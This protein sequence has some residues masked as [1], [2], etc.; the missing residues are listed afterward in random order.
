MRILQNNHN[1]IINWSIPLIQGL[2]DSLS[3]HKSIPVLCN[4]P[5]ALNFTS[6]ILLCNLLLLIGSVIMYDNGLFPSLQ[7][8]KRLVYNNMSSEN[9]VD[10]SFVLDAA[11]SFYRSFWILPVYF[12]CYICN[13]IW[14]QDLANCLCKYFKDDQKKIASKK[15]RDL[16]SESVFKAIIWII[17][18]SKVQIILQI[19]PHF[20]N[21]LAT[22]L[23]DKFSLFGFGMSIFCRLF[24]GLC[25]LI[26]LVLMSVVYAWYSFDATWDVMGTSL[27]QRFAAMD[28]NWLYFVGFGLHA[29]II[30]KSSS[31]FVGYGLFMLC[32]PF[33][34]IL[35]KVSSNIPKD[36]D[37]NKNKNSGRDVHIP[38]FKTSQ[39]IAIYILKHFKFGAIST[40][41]R[42]LTKD[43]KIS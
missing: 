26:G 41:K 32:F 34:I 6:K 38:F 7:Y 2:T 15:S 35:A 22:I 29:T 20:G 39:S 11:F 12:L 18:F 5:E 16:I 13:T 33:S 17:V 40:K 37:S 19:F 23:F 14:C 43:K 1:V 10:Q 21:S 24:A 8:L 36:I 3:L 27:N 30:I 9:V 42:E 28:S 31:F 25:Y 4:C